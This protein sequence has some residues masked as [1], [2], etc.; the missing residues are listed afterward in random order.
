MLNTLFN[1]LKKSRFI[2]TSYKSYMI[3]VVFSF[4]FC[5]SC[6]DVIDINLN[7]ADQK[8]VIEGIITNQTEPAIVII[9][10]TTDYFSP[11]T[12]QNVTGA[13]V[14]ISDDAGN[15]DTLQELNDGDYQ[16]NSLRGVPGRTYSLSVAVD[17]EIYS[18]SSTMPEPLII[19]SLECEFKTADELWPHSDSAGYLLHCYF[20]DPPGDDTYCRIKVYSFRTQGWSERYYLYYGDYSD[21][22]SINYQ[23]FYGIYYPNDTLW[24]YLYAIEEDMF[25]YYWTLSQVIASDDRDQSSSTPAN[26]NTNLSGDALGYFS[27]MT[28]SRDSIIA[29]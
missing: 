25:F 17:G 20:T 12:F 3:F 10:K 5:I 23:N 18:A 19:D 1:S 6:E 27:A 26:P 8:I 13:I 21:G 14:I 24:V 4:M 22:N 15:S 29:Q 28:V 11:N 9:S 7:S 16:G 2:I